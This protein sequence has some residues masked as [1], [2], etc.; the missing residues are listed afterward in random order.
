MGASLRDRS[1]TNNCCML[2]G[3]TVAITTGNGCVVAST[4]PVVAPSVN[5]ALF[6][7]DE[8]GSP[9]RDRAPYTVCS[10]E[11]STTHAVLE[12]SPAD[13]VAQNESIIS[14]SLPQRLSHS[15]AKF[16]K[17]SRDTFPIIP[18]PLP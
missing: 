14:F 2:T 10:V 17:I 13:T 9:T 5:A 4:G 6:T 8:A 3:S 16:S 15:N 1:P 18:L 7:C 12:L 11:F